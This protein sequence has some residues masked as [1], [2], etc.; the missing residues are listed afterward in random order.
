MRQLP[1]HKGAFMCVN[2]Q[3]PLCKGRWQSVSFDGGIVKSP[4]QTHNRNCTTACSLTQCIGMT[5]RGENIYSAL[6]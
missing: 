4:A 3:P 6:L 5:A 1:L 2:Y